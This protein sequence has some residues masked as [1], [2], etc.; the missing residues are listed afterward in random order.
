MVNQ[1]AIK[2]AFSKIKQDLE[3]IKMEIQN[4]KNK[5]NDFNSY[6]EIIGEKK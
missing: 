5:I 3:L 2:E 1:E 4:L 6:E